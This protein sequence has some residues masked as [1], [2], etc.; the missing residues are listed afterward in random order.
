[1]IAMLCCSLLSFLH[2]IGLSVV[3]LYIHQYIRSI[4]KRWTE[5]KMRE[6]VKMVYVMM[7][8]RAN[9]LDERRRKKKH[10]YNSQ[11]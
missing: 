4:K 3:G 1:M 8:V 6:K 11:A 2:C 9:L 10:L 7:T 5:K